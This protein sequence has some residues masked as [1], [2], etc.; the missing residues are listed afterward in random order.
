MKTSKTILW[1]SILAAVLGLSASIT[2]LFS[3]GGPGPSSFTNVFGQTIEIYG[4]G[5][6]H[7]DPTFNAGIFIGTDLIALIALPVLI[8]AMILYR[9]G[10]LRGR[11]LL[12]GMLVY[13]LYYGVS[14]AIGSMYNSIFLVYIAL[15][16]ASL[17][18]TILVFSSIDTAS[19]PARVSP[20]MPH[21]GIAIFLI[22]AG[23][24]VSLIWLLDIITSLLTG[25]APANMGT[26][27]T[28]ITD[29]L[30]IGVI[31]PSC[32]IA[33]ILLLR[34][35]PLGY[36]I[37]SSMLILC[38]G[39]GLVVVSQTF[40][41]KALGIQLSVAQMIIFVVTFVIMSLF[42]VGLSIRFFRGLSE[43]A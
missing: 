19:L 41:Q 32:V 9:R 28:N 20:R 18:A 31:T 37:A 6:Y 33:G 13:F 14:L 24:S 1:L 30:D 35:R 12:L 7:R 22:I 23:V 43:P 39:I 17:F 5:I 36:P 4:R 38:T 21:R 11:F 8:Y 27:T 25:Q 42:A 34:R 29:V 15:F 3:R 2:G 10:S 40:F 16:S 26:Y